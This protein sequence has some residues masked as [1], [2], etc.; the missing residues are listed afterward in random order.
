MGSRTP[1]AA[2]PQREE[3][4]LRLYPVPLLPALAL[5]C[6]LLAALLANGRPIGAGDTRATE[7]VAAS[8][9]QELDLDLDE[10]PEVE[11]PFA[12][13]VGER[14][15]S[16][17]PVLSAVLAAPVF[18]LARP[19]FAL[20][21]AGTALA[22][23]LAASL[24]SALAAATLYVA[25]GRRRSLAEAR[26]AAVVLA[27]GTGLWAA[28]QGLW[29]HPAAALFVSLAVL[30]AVEAEDDES[31]AG[32]A[33]LP[34]GLAFAARHA[35]AALVVALAAGIALRWPRRIPR[36]LLWSL[37]PL[38]FV[39]F[40]QW[41]AFGSPLQTGFAD[42]LAR[43]SEPWG[44]GHA[45]LL[46]SPAKGL[47]VFTPV[48]L[49]A[50]YGLL[51]A[52]RGEERWLASTFGA[53]LV[54]HW[55][56]MGRW[57]EWH[58][59]E[60]WGP[61]LMTDALPLLIF[62]LPEGL[63]RWPRAGAALAALS[64][65]IQALGAFAYDYRWERLHQRPGAEATLWDVA[66]GPIPFH[67][68]ERVLILALP[69]VREGRAFVRTHPVVPFASSGSRV[70]FAGGVPLVTGSDRTLGNVHLQRGARVEQGRL[71]LRANWDALF[72]RVPPAARSRRLELRI[73]GQGRGPLYV[74]E[75]T[76]WSDA[77]RFA[78]YAASGAFRIRHPYHYPESG[79][80]D[81]TV[82]TGRGHGDVQIEWVALVP[83][84]EPD[85]P[86]RLGGE[87]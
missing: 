62:F 24:L 1:E 26:L 27:L 15:F 65:G 43:F 76:F 17:Y 48:A 86:I 40:Y 77:P 12:R 6:A 9:V 22:G 46:L 11:P 70:E 85:N 67:V 32:R 69:G 38:L 18:A 61:R 78:T 36:L 5:G 50:A 31:W 68:R 58:G 80:A 82:T 83:P 30:F 64:I 57:S 2:E 81:V 74:S 41:T 66:D 53:A 72:L 49:V 3:R 29:Q 25:I 33:G 13:V 56:L 10:Y 28:S 55:L 63:E 51:R 52:L 54:A 34:L 14:R 4:Q 71:R 84:N 44:R 79:G 35:D 45:G 23:K 42:G 7:R 21:E 20:D 87:R 37:P 47:L 73:S 16:I 59:G 8:L 39:A 60:S 75:R 19:F